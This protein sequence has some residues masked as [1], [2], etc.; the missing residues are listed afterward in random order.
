M[1]L[2]LPFTIERRGKVDVVVEKREGGGLRSAS[3]VEVAL[4]EERTRTKILLKA[5][6]QHLVCQPHSP[7]M[8]C[9]CPKC[10]IEAHLAE[11]ED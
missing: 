7:I 3:D 10:I 2:K 11:L 9:I 8:A 5:A 6:L 4:W 1:E